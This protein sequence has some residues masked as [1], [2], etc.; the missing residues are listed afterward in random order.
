MSA[1]F[2]AP[3]AA[4]ILARLAADPAFAAIVAEYTAAQL[5]YSTTSPATYEEM[6]DASTRCYLAGESLLDAYPGAQA[7]R[8]TACDVREAVYARRA[9]DATE[10]AAE[11][12]A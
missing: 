2:V 12:D 9:V 3:T 10:K 8:A 7:A 6:R 4:E 1:R 11:V 5:A